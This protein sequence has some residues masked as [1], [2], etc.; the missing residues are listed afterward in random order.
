MTGTLSLSVGADAFDVSRVRLV[1]PEIGAWFADLEYDGDAS[2]PAGA[3]AK[4][5]ING[6]TWIGTVESRR[7]G[8]AGRRV[9]AR[10]VAGGGGWSALVPAKSWHNEN[11]VTLRNVAETTAHEAKEQIGSCA[12]VRLGSHYVRDAGPAA[13]VLGDSWFVDSNGVTHVK[14]RAPLRV[15]AG[16]VDVLS[17]DP[18]LQIVT[19]G[20]DEPIAPSSVFAGTQFGDLAVRDV[21]QI[22]EPGNARAICFVGPSGASRIRA[23]L[24][25]AVRA[26]AGTNNAIEHTYRVY[27]MDGEA[28]KVQAVSKSYP[29]LVPAPIWYGLPGASSELRPGQLVQVC[30]QNGD[31]GSPVVVAF[32]PGLP[33]KTRIDAVG[34]IALGGTA[35]KALAIAEYAIARDDAII[36][37]LKAL[38]AAMSALVITPVQGGVLG[39]AITTA[40]TGAEAALQAAANSMACT[41]AK[42]E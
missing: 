27:A 15:T 20:H 37:A 31:R 22:F 21:E 9:H 32:A 29:D 12:D 18:G 28:V 36:D 1:Q 24:A 42:G 16:S 39:T 7:T 6:T 26:V 41:K 17:Y 10:I 13:S 34:E 5:E 2:P 11:G 3:V 38:A 40:L 23:A 8:I 25:K 35:A 30:L 4:V 14:A 33:Q 19:V